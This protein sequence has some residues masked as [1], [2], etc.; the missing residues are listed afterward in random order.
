MSQCS[1]CINYL[2][3]LRNNRLVCSKW[4]LNFSLI[5]TENL[6]SSTTWCGCWEANLKVIPITRKLDV[7][8]TLCVHFYLEWKNTHKTAFPCKDCKN[9]RTLLMYFSGILKCDF[10]NNWMVLLLF[11]QWARR[12]DIIPETKGGKW[13]DDTLLL[14]TQLFRNAPKVSREAG[15][16]SDALSLAWILWCSVRVELRVKALPHLVHL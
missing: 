11:P 9:Y 13:L 12:S 10:S 5:F 3:S 14:Y 16:Y 1:F 7:L 6:D 2:S 4:L 8:H 15:L